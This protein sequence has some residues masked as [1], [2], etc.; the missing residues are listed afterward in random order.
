[1]LITDIDYSI[2][3]L[4]L[5]DP[6]RIQQVL[7]NLLKNA[8]KF[9]NKGYIRLTIQLCKKNTELL[10]KIQ[11]SGI[12]VSDTK[13]KEIFDN[14]FQAHNYTSRQ[15]GGTGLGLAISKDLVHLMNGKIGVKDNLPGGSIFWFTLPLLLPEKTTTTTFLQKHMATI[16]PQTKILLIDDSIWALRSLQQKL[17]T[18]GASNVDTAQGAE[19]ALIMIKKQSRLKTPYDIVMVDMIM[20]KMDGWR[21]A[22]TLHSDK[23]IRNTTLYLIIPEGQLGGEAKM[24]MLDWFNGYMY[25][26]IKLKNLSNMLH[27]HFNTP[28]DLDLSP[29]ELAENK[30]KTTGQHT[31]KILVAEDHPV[32]R[33]LMATFLFQTQAIVYTATNGKEAVHDVLK[34]PDIDLIF[35]DIQMPVK[36]GIEATKEIRASG[37]TGVIIACTANTDKNNIEHYAH[38]GINDVL[39]KP[40]KREKVQAILQ[41]W[42]QVFNLAQKDATP[43]T[44]EFMKN[45][46]SSVFWDIPDMIDTA[47]NDVQLSS[48]LVLQYIEQ[49]KKLIKN[50]EERANSGN[51]EKLILSA[52]TIKGSSAAL[53]I[54]GILEPADLLEEAAKKG[55][56]EA[57]K[58]HLNRIKELFIDFCDLAHKQIK[59][60]K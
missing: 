58:T 42:E 7:L 26:P 40:F 54:I 48:E 4:I 17:H 51:T 25:K 46:N 24:K 33:K 16:P 39:V 29:D 15:F 52:H 60:W 22:A 2:P 55:D 14:Y 28:I 44:T 20:P 38:I 11:D 49:T 23:N 34:N 41:K 9:T 37:Y 36:N 59:K 43:D 30:K 1:E 32:N 53:S 21:F 13:K 19:Q 47:G 5:G 27:T 35:M 31:P 56:V 50:A 57:A 18:L 6:T 8:V 45:N 10:F 3:Y 12:G